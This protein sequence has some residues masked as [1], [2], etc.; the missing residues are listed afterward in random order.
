MSSFCSRE[1]RLFSVANPSKVV[2]DGQRNLD[3]YLAGRCVGLL[4]GSALTNIKSR[5]QRHR[6]IS[7]TLRILPFVPL[8]D[9]DRTT[10]IFDRV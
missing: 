9:A 10:R 1:Q 5:W 3:S 6:E 8:D 2:T 4:A 7:K